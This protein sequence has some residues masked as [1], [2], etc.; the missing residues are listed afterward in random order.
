MKLNFLFSSPPSPKRWPACPCCSA[1]PWPPI[2]RHYFTYIP[3]WLW[4]V[5]QNTKHFYKLMSSSTFPSK[6]TKERQPFL[7]PYEDSVRLEC[8]S[9]TFSNSAPLWTQ[10]FLVLKDSCI[11]CSALG[12]MWSK[13]CCDYHSQV[14]TPFEDTVIWQ[15]NWNPWLST[16]TALSVYQCLST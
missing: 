3:E 9:R 7:N 2:Y 10:C 13:L 6:H 4:R 8:F 5:C 15:K 1:A 12:V 11:S 16:V 14:R